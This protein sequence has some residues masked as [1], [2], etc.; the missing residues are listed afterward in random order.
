MQTLADP[1][2]RP[3]YLIKSGGENKRLTYFATEILLLL[4][5][6]CKHSFVPNLA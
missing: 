4:C 5:E 2:H 6:G 3:L 1:L